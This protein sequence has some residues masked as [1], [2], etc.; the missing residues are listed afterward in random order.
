MCHFSSHQAEKSILSENFGTIKDTG[1]ACKESKI[2][3]KIWEVFSLL[4]TENANRLS[5]SRL[6][7]CRGSIPPATVCKAPPPP[8]IV[9]PT[10]PSLSERNMR[11]MCGQIVGVRAKIGLPNLD[12]TATPISCQRQGLIMRWA[13]MT[14][15]CVMEM[16]TAIAE[17]IW[18]CSG[19]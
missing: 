16:M 3:A 12:S 14:R 8:S 7:G 4:R 5:I 9:F 18:S 6:R 11:A 15:L 10:S 17:R 1:T 13:V 19:N 2:G